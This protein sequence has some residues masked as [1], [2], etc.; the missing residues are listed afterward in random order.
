[1]T[2]ASAALDRVPWGVVVADHD[3]KVLELNAAAATHLK[4]GDAL[5]LCNDKIEAALINRNA[6]LHRLIGEAAGR[7]KARA[8]SSL[9]R[10]ERQSG[11]GYLTILVAPLRQTA[12]RNGLK[13]QAGTILFIADSEQPVCSAALLRQ[14]FGLTPSE[15]AVT[16]AIANGKT[17]GE[18][19]AQNSVSRNTIRVQAQSILAKTGARRQAELVRLI[20]QLPT[21]R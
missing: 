20:L 15:A 2:S 5:R 9:L 1:M 18:I 13:P 10:F 21:V 12:Q 17:L 19:A 4:R 8:T 3:A 14:L 16:Q 6:E 7:G 11:K